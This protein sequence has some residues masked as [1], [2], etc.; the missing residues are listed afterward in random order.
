MAYVWSATCLGETL[1]IHQFSVHDP[2]ASV[3]VAES[4][5]SAWVFHH[6]GHRDAHEPG[7]QDAVGA[8]AEA[9]H[10]DHRIPLSCAE[11]G[12][13]STAKTPQP[14][15][16]P[17]DVPVI[18]PLPVPYDAVGVRLPRCVGQPPVTRHAV[19]VLVRQTRLRI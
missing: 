17:A 16:L 5:G 7:V 11:A 19:H 15:K 6:A 14:D 2:H 10:A 9:G 4:E 1:L 3:L 18:L 12:A 8:E 13:A